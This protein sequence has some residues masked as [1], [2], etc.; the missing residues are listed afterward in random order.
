MAKPAGGLETAATTSTA[1]S[2]RD[3]GS[4]KNSTQWAYEQVLVLKL[5]QAGAQPFD[6]AQRDRRMNC[7]VARF[8]SS[9]PM[10]ETNLAL[11][12]EVVQ[13]PMALLRFRRERAGGGVDAEVG[14]GG[15]WKMCDGKACTIGIDFDA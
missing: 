14:N 3:A 10:S 12:A 15:I 4:T 6:P 13:L 7:A 9:G 2:R 11:G 8:T 5:R 1:K